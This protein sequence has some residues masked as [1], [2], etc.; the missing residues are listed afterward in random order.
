MHV[1]YCDEL[2]IVS[3]PQVTSILA[4]GMVNKEDT[5]RLIFITIGNE[6]KLSAS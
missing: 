5:Q 4:L 1:F 2:I 3:C 6:Q